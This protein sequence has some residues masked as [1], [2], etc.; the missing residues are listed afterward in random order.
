MINLCGISPRLLF[1]GH[2]EL[3]SGSYNRDDMKAHHPNP[4]TYTTFRKQGRTTRISLAPFVPLVGRE[5]SLSLV[6]IYAPETGSHNSFLV[7]SLC[8]VQD[9]MASFT[10]VQCV[11]LPQAV[12]D[13]K[14]IPLALRERVRERGR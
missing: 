12:R 7:G 11:V 9:D 1:K 13:D 8:K 4:P 6:L 2:P 14:N 3:V 5:K 10:N